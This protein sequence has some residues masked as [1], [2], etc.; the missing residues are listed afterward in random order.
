MVHTAP[1]TPGARGVARRLLHRTTPSVRSVA[2]LCVRLEPPGATEAMFVPRDARLVGVRPR[3]M[4]MR[5]HRAIGYGPERSQ[6]EPNRR[7]CGRHL[8]HLDVVDQQA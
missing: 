6:D 7:P 4:M 5:G 2:A 8:T 3:P 1:P